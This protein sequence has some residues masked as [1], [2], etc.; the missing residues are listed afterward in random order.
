M[1]T[2]MLCLLTATPWVRGGLVFKKHSFARNSITYPDQQRK[3]MCVK[4]N[5]SSGGAGRVNLQK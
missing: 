5:S 2:E 4:P 1:Y 3:V